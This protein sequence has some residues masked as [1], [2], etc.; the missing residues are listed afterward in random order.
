MSAPTRAPRIGLTTY[1]TQARWGVWH[2][3]AALVPASYLD[4]VVAAG[5]APLL[6]PPVGPGTD[7]LDAVDALIVIGGTDVDPATYGADALPTTISEPR[8]DETDLAL[9]AA[10]LERGMPLLA[11]CRGA[12]VLNVALG[13]SLVQHLPDVLGHDDYRPEPGVFGRVGY[14]T[15]PG[16]RIASIVGEQGMSPCYHHQAIDR[17]ADGLR[18][19]ARSADGVVQAVE[20]DGGAFALG[21]QFHP[22][23][24]ASDRRLFTAFL[25]TVR[26]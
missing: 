1:Y 15:T 6:L 26:G 9:T 14:T 11:I 4:A 22:E 19:T 20:R 5:G 17:V 7:V 23:E 18:V 24:D 12:Q 8:R 10:A 2:G 21:V 16:S 25:D 13:G 3:A